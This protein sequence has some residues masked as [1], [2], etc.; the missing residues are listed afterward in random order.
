MIHCW[1]YITSYAHISIQVELFSRTCGHVSTQV[2]GNIIHAPNLNYSLHI[3]V[4]V[5]SCA[6]L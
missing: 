1:G 4:C 5:C 2:Q 6:K 3:C